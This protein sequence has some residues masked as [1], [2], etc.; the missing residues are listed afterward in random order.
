MPEYTLQ[1]DYSFAGGVPAAPFTIHESMVDK[2]DPEYVKFFNS[3]LSSNANIVYTHRVPLKDL[4]SSGNVIPGQTP[5]NDMAKIFDIQIPRKHTDGSGLVGARVF[6]PHGTAPPN[7]W[8]LVIWYHGGGWVLGNIGTE[9]SYCTKIAD[10]A[11]S[12]VVSV[13]YRLAPDH[14]YPAAVHD[15]YEALLW[16]FE[17]APKELGIDNTRICVAGSSAG[18]N[19]TAIVTHKYASSAFSREYPPVKFHYLVVPVTDNTATGETM[20]SWKENE[21]TT[22]LP[23]EKMLWYRR[24]YLQNGEHAEPESSSLLYPDESFAKLPPCFIACCECD[25]LRSEAEAYAEKLKK[26][27][28][29][30]SIVVYPGM[31]H[32]A[33]VMDAVMQQGK[34]LVRDTTEAA[35]KALYDS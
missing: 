8:P 13:D 18:G 22:Q 9:N 19:L 17:E 15:A 20:P 5:M 25:V 26:N 34:D 27:G 12:I 24:L 7:G 10:N 32:P 14:P 21:F 6:V 30:T 3:T 11:K 33:M 1:D 4:R 28:V 35:R 31:P 2:L 29:P 23:A 16:G